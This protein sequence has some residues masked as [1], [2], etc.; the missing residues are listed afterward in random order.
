M[1]TQNDFGRILADGQ[2]QTLAAWKSAVE[3]SFDLGAELMTLHKEYVLRVAD[4]FGARASKS[5]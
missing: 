3:S 1:P 5:A 2:K 4:V